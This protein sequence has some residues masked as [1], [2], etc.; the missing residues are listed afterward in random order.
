MSRWSI[1]ATAA[2]GTQHRQTVEAASAPEAAAALLPQGL[3]AYCV[4]ETGSPRAHR[5]PNADRSALYGELGALLGAR[6]PLAAALGI[7]AAGSDR[8]KVRAAAREIGAQVEAGG[9]LSEAL[10]SRGG[11]ATEAATVAAGEARGDTGAA[12]GRLTTLLTKRAAMERA[13]LGALI[14]PAV[15]LLVTLLS[16][17]LILLAV[18]PGL[19]PLLETP[20]RDIP[21]SAALVLGASALLRDHGTA[22]G[23]A[24][25]AC[26][27]TGLLLRRHPGLHRR[28]ERTALGLPILGRALTAT[29]TATALRTAA[30][31]IEGGM[32]L[33]AAFDHAAGAVRLSGL[34]ADLRG[35]AADLRAGVAIEAAVARATHLAK[36]I[37]GLITVGARTGDLARML[38][39][40][41]ERLERDAE[42]RIARL[43]ALLP[44][45]VTLL[46][47]GLVGGITVVIFSAILSAN[48]FAF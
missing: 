19:A 43:L 36:G 42:A 3:V 21:P 38:A 20:G 33:P 5:L 7:V 35:I 8:P 9:R 45:A 4:R 10:Q 17:A 39:T 24:S 14:Y 12:L 11:T 48:D 32:R 41:A 15:L 26:L 18:V 16:L 2:D 34:A 46:L 25:A 37:A 6:I 27:G 13:L 29:E 28:V 30:G 40:A 1:R 47:G 22:L 44:P 31:L 23:A